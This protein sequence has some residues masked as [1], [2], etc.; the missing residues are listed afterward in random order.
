MVL[1]RLGRF[2]H[3][4]YGARGLRRYSKFI[5]AI[6]SVCL[7][8]GTATVPSV[9]H[10]GLTRHQSRLGPHQLSAQVGGMI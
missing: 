6:V 7:R 5:G 9:L 3:P 2:G 4:R 1:L 8:Q 10:V